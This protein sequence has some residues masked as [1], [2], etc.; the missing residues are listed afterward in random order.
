MLAIARARRPKYISIMQYLYH[1]NKIIKI[2]RY[3]NVNSF[4]YGQLWSF[5]VLST[6]FCSP[7]TRLQKLEVVC[8]PRASAKATR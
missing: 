4:N 7:G 6:S 2:N 5:N 8:H 1:N 3:S